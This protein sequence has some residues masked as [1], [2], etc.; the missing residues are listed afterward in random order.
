ML[1]SYGPASLATS[2]KAVQD[3]AR[4]WSGKAD[5]LC[6]GSGRDVPV[7]LQSS[8]SGK[9]LNCPDL[10]KSLWEEAPHRSCFCTLFYCS[11]MDVE[12]FVF[13]V[14]FCRLKLNKKLITIF[15]WRFLFNSSFIMYKCSVMYSR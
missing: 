9:S 11:Y 15:H 14:F 13:F 8:A 4:F 12:V 7:G 2:A 10:S 3:F 6:G 5:F 1:C